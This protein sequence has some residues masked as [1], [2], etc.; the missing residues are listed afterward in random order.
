MNV[1]VRIWVSSEV[2]ADFCRRH[3]FLHRANMSLSELRAVWDLVKDVRTYA[4][5]LNCW[6][7]VLAFWNVNLNS[8]NK[9]LYKIGNYHVSLNIIWARIL[10]CQCLQLQLKQRDL[11]GRR[12]CCRRCLPSHQLSHAC[13]FLRV[14]TICR[15]YAVCWC[16]CPVRSQLFS[17]SS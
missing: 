5:K 10:C 17:S 11:H 6:W 12:H 8:R 15:Q 14:W 13:A 1:H 2:V 9:H 7:D 4:E 16:H 3:S